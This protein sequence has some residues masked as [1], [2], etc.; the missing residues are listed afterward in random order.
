MTYI[1]TLYELLRLFLYHIGL[2]SFTIISRSVFFSC[3]IVKYCCIYCWMIY[4]QLT[5]E[6]IFFLLV[7]ICPCIELLFVHSSSFHPFF[8][9]LLKPMEQ[10]YSQPLRRALDSSDNRPARRAQVRS[11]I[12]I[13]GYAGL[14]QAL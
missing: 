3:L 7:Y 13:V 11:V 5:H 14:C 10:V 1:Y 2:F 8:A 4:F 12:T 6:K 9:F